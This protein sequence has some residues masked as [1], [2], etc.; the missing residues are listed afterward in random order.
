MNVWLY[1]KVT[2]CLIRVWEDQHLGFVWKVNLLYKCTLSSVV[3]IPCVWSPI[4]SLNP[5]LTYRQNPIP[6]KTHSYS[7]Y[8]DFPVNCSDKRFSGNI[9]RFI[10]V[11][12]F[13]LLIWSCFNT[14]NENHENLQKVILFYLIS[15][16]LCLIPSTLL[17]SRW[18]EMPHNPWK[19][20]FW[21]FWLKPM[22]R[23]SAHFE[24]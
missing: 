17:E 6:M 12:F 3:T 11:F 8:C 22:C 16:R 19:I 10:F 5:S 4:H 15:F 23:H 13:C 14:L 21:F 7:L 1:I 9:S 20:Q 18:D 24:Q 2:W